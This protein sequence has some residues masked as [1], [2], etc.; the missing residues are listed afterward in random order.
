MLKD[1]QGVGL[2]ESRTAREKDGEGEGG[3]LGS[4]KLVDAGTEEER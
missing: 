1:C 4:S 3:F 2:Q